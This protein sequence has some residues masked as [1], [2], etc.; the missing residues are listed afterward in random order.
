MENG[1][2]TGSFNIFERVIDGVGLQFEVRKK[3]LVF[4]HWDEIATIFAE[5][6]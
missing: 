3:R 2:F 4:P 5:D 6:D 1:R